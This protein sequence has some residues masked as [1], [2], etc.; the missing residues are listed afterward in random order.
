MRNPRFP[1][2]FVAVLT[3]AACTVVDDKPGAWRDAGAATAE[4]TVSVEKPGAPISYLI[5]A[6]N[7]VLG[8]MQA[9]SLRVPVECECNCR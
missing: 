8:E 1:L 9:G 6:H 4:R 2:A 3:M 5:E 7:S